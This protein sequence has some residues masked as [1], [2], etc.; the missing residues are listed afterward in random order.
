VADEYVPARDPG[1]TP[2][3]YCTSVR[4][5]VTAMKAVD[6]TIQIIGQI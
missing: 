2:S 5:F 1:Y 6:P 3:D 4:A